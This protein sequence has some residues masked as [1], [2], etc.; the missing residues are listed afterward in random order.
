MNLHDARSAVI[1]T[2]GR[3]NALYNKTVF[4]EW[5]LVKLAT[6]VGIGDKRAHAVLDSDEFVDAVHSDEREAMELGIN[7]VPFFVIN[8]RYGVSGAQPPEALL[9][10]LEMAWNE[11]HPVEVESGE[12][13]T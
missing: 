3:M 7:G 12:V 1:L 5:V 6:E 11:A 13:G 8:R 9:D 4:D 10:A 2:L